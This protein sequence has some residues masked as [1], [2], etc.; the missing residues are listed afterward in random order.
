MWQIVVSLALCASSLRLSPTSPEEG[1]SFSKRKEELPSWGPLMKYVKTQIREGFPDRH[2]KKVDEVSLTKSE[3]G[4]CNARMI[5][6][7]NEKK[8][9]SGYGSKVNNFMNQLAL[10]SYGGFSVSMWSPGNFEGTWNKYFDSSLPVCKHAEEDTYPGLE[11]GSRMFFQELAKVDKDYVVQ[12]KRAVYKANY[13]YNQKTADQI[14]QVLKKFELPEKYFGLHVRTGDKVRELADKTTGIQKYADAILAKKG[15]GIR[16][17]WLA[18][19]DPDVEKQLGDA[20]GEEYDIKV[21]S[22]NDGQW[23][24]GPEEVYQEGSEKMQN[25]L[26]DVEALRRSTHFIGTASSNMGRLVYFLRDDEQGKTAVSLDE[27]FLARAA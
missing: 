12:Q 3:E 10:A 20:L 18:T 2:E 19:V 25:L 7:F 23:K 16:T 13:K 8:P 6:G 1:K 24:R 4:P 5:V 17:V 14:E 21:L 11:H 15:E 9:T 27:D 22:G 26:V